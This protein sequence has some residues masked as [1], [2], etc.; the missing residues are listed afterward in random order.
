MSRSSRSDYA[1]YQ[2]LERALRLWE[3]VRGRPVC[4]SV[5]ELGREIGVCSRTVRRYLDALTLAGMD[6]PPLRREYERLERDSR[7]LPGGA[8]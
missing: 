2:S 8:R 6:V 7:L 5:E 1:R 3:M 4:Q